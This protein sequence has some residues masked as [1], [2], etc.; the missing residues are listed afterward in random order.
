MVTQMSCSKSSD[1]FGHIRSLFRVN[2]T[3]KTF[4]LPYLLKG[5]ATHTHAR[6]HALLSCQ[7][8]GPP[9]VR[10]VDIDS[11]EAPSAGLISEDFPAQLHANMTHDR[12]HEMSVGQCGPSW[13]EK[14]PG[15]VGRETLNQQWQYHR[16]EPLQPTD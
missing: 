6:P 4:G 7:T 13:L 10:Q 8:S 1:H 14:S 3:T 15:D 2:L 9:K 12:P 16:I 11:L 5:I